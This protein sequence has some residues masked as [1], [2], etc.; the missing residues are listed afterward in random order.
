MT[1][2]EETPTH[3]HQGSSKREK[4]KH[5]LMVV[6]EWNLVHTLG[7]G[8]LALLNAGLDGLVELGIKGSLRGDIDLVV[9]RNIFLDG[10][11]AELKKL[12]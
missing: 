8:E 11:T 6:W 10:L 2:Y 5:V 4:K 1:G 7:L 12:D 9:G 3:Q